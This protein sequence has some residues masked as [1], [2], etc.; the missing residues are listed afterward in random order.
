MCWQLLWFCVVTLVQVLFLFQTHFDQD[1]SLVGKSL[2]VQWLRLGAFT[3]GAQVQ[4]LVGQLRFHKLS[5]A[6]KKKKK[7][8][9]WLVHRYFTL[10]VSWSEPMFSTEPAP[11][12]GS[13]NSVNVWS[14]TQFLVKSWLIRAMLNSPCHWASLSVFR[15]M[16]WIYSPSSLLMPLQSNL[17]SRSLFPLFPQA[18]LCSRH[19]GD[20]QIH[21]SDHFRP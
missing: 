12:P 2:V 8:P 10:N 15:W 5:G 17:H 11:P 1:P 19:C 18:S 20:S 7:T 16:S 14:S 6:A 9:I 3:A 13:L 21:T 4:S